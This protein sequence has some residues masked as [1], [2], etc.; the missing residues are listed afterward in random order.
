MIVSQI[1]IISVLPISSFL[2]FSSSHNQLHLPAVFTFISSGINYNLTGTLNPRLSVFFLIEVLGQAV[3]ASITQIQIL[4]NCCSSK[5]ESAVYAPIFDVYLQHFQSLHCSLL[6]GSFF[7]GSL[8]YKENIQNENNWEKV[9]TWCLCFTCCEV[10]FLFCI[11][12]NLSS[13]LNM[14]FSWW[15]QPDTT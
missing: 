3:Y 13:G 2:L 9:L 4:H 11:I 10:D 6:F 14:P 1:H 15:F 12:L 7:R 5:R 8:A